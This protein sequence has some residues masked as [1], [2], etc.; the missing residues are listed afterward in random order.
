MNGNIEK[1][2][3]LWI[4][5]HW[6]CQRIGDSKIRKIRGAGWMVRLTIGSKRAGVFQEGRS[7]NKSF[8]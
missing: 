3:L 8:G 2:E 4:L 6:N 1:D 5:L 7:C